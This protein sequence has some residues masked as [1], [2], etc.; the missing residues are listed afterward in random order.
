MSRMQKFAWFNLA[1]IA[2]TLLVVFALLPFVGHRAMGGLGFLG[3][4]AMDKLSSH[5]D[6]AADTAVAA[7]VLS[8]MF[9]GKSDADRARVS[10]AIGKLGRMGEEAERAEK[11]ARASGSRVSKSSPRG[12]LDSILPAV[13][14]AVESAVGHRDQLLRVFLQNLRNRQFHWAIVSDQHDSAGD[15]DLAIGEGV[16]GVG[17]LFGAHAL[18]GSNFDLHALSREIV[19]AAHL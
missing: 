10:D 9:G 16:K 5:S 6:G 12:P 17:Q 2:L 1:V 19:D 11:A 14:G 15:R 8:S 4:G 7:G 18:R 3:L 13:L